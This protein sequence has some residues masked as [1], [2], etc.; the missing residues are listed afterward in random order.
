MSLKKKNEVIEKLN[1]FQEK[2]KITSHDFLNVDYFRIQEIIDFIEEENKFPVEMVEEVNDLYS[3]HVN[4]NPLGI[5]KN[6]YDEIVE[7]LKEG[8]KIKAIKEYK[9]ETGKGLKE[10]KEIIDEFYDKLQRGLIKPS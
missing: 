2:I 7:L 9:I 1:D 3:R 4:T 10:S 6:V 8:Y 5:A